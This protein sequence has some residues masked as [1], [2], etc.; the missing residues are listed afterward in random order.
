MRNSTGTPAQR[1]DR[2]PQALSAG[3]R[4]IVPHGP[5]TRY[6]QAAVDRIRETRP[7]LV[8]DQALARLAPV[9]HAHINPYGRY[10]FDLTA[11]PAAGQ[12]RPL[13]TPPAARASDVPSQPIP[14][15]RD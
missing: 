13:N 7:E 4:S 11:A 10:R 12:L 14:L 9:L 2:P 3:S 15:N 8:N 1:T 6:I 5:N